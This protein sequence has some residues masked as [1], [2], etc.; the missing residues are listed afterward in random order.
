MVVIYLLVR[1]GV[2]NCYL[3][4]SG[5]VV[6]VEWR[7]DYVLGSAAVEGLGRDLKNCGVKRYL[8]YCVVV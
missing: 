5:G 1:G 8:G 7:A 2:T 6:T 3:V 4:V